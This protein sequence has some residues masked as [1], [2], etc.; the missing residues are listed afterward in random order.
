MTSTGS[1]SVRLSLD[2]QAGSQLDRVFQHELGAP[3][4]YDHRKLDFQQQ[5]HGAAR[6]RFGSGLAD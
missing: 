5:I 2:D 6:A 4:G 1:L 3:E